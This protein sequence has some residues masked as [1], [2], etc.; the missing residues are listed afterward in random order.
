MQALCKHHSRSSKNTPPSEIRT[1]HIHSLTYT[2]TPPHHT[3]NLPDHADHCS[4]DVGLKFDIAVHNEKKL[5]PYAI[6]EDSYA[7][8]ALD[9][10][11]IEVRRD[12]SGHE[13]DFGWESWLG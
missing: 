11:L 8:H 1:I 6:R 13:R 7:S 5:T 10:K 12:T 3:Q 2:Q 4:S 9:T